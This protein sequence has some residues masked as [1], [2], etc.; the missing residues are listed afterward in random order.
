MCNGN[1]RRKGT[2]TLAHTFGACLEQAGARVFWACT[3]LLQMVVMGADASNAFAEASPPKSPLYVIVDKQYREWWEA[4]GR[5]PIPPGHV[6]PVQHALQ[7]HPESPRLWAQMIDKIIRTHVGLQPCRHEPCLYHGIVDGELVLFLRQVDDFAVTCSDTVI[8]D[9]VIDLISAHLSAPM[10]KLG[11]VTRY[12]GVDINQTSDY[13]KIHSTTY[14]KKILENHDWN[15]DKEKCHVAPIPMKEDASYQT[16]LDTTPVPTND[17]EREQLENDMGYSYRQA[18]G[19]VLFAMVTCRPDISFCVI[20]LSKYSNNPGREHY[21]ALKSIFKYLRC[22]MDDG[23]MYWKKN[24]H[25]HKY[26]IP[27]TVPRL[28]HKQNPKPNNQRE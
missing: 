21:L 3:A 13:I 7:G 1:P 4:K 25:T 12:N 22:T 17:I 2:V 18:L 26:L 19:E 10:K 14:L 16:I 24:T 27:P 15:N 9:K 28:F 20:K 5:D 8:S 6:L 11:V 23:I